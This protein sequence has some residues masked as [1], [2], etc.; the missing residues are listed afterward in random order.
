MEPTQKL[1]MLFSGDVLPGGLLSNEGELIALIQ[2][3][4]SDLSAWK[5]AALKFRCMGASLDDLVFKEDCPEEIREK[6]LR[7]GVLISRGDLSEEA[8]LV[9][10]AMMKEALAKLPA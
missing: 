6:K 2:E 9:V 8:L 3:W 1:P 10:A 5:N 4:D 7:I